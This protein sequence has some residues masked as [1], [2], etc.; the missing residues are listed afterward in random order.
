MPETLL[1]ALC[2]WY[3][4]I[5]TMSLKLKKMNLKLKQGKCPS[6]PLLGIGETEFKT[7]FW[8]TPKLFLKDFIFLHYLP[9]LFLLFSNN[10]SQIV[11]LV[12]AASAP[13]GNLL[14][15]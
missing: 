1:R 2:L 14:E 12:P 9:L 15:M 8:S 5:L 10:G 7:K 3:P 6:I 4:L 13:P 11:I